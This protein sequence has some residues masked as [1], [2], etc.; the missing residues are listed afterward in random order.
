MTL[1]GGATTNGTVYELT[2]DSHGKWRHKTLHNFCVRSNCPDGAQPSSSL[3]ADTKGNL[4]GT[5]LAGGKTNNGVVFELMPPD[6]QRSKWKIKILH[7]F[8]LQTCTDGS[9]YGQDVIEGNLTYAGAASGA[10][11]D[12]V[13]ALYGTTHAGGQSIGNSGGVVYSLTPSG[14]KWQ[15]SV[16]YSFCTVS[17]CADG[18]AP[19]GGLVIDA[20]GN[21][22]GTTMI[23]GTGEGTA[24]ELSPNA[25][26]T[27][28]TETVLYNFCSSGCAG[29]AL[30]SGRLVI[31]TMGNL[32]GTSRLGGSG[33][34]G[35]AFKLVPNGTASQVTPLYDFCSQ[36][37]AESFCTDGTRPAA[38]LTL[39][40][41]GRLFGTT[42][43]GGG[44]SSDAPYGGGV[45]FMLNGT[46]QVIHPFCALF[47]C[48]DGEYPSSSLALDEAGNLYGTTDGGG[49]PVGIE[50]CYS[51][52][53]IRVDALA[54]SDHQIAGGISASC[55]GELESPGSTEGTGGPGRRDFEPRIR[56][57][58]RSCTN[59]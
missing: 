39:D 15:A 41:S 57:P 17:G 27:T 24:F 59:R 58:G 8:C 9:N 23:G 4:Y 56:L 47:D 22:Y 35:V 21:L 28:W 54:Q 18:Q 14:N 7:S 53:R 48:A 2:Q 36:N 55:A 34:G 16:L 12:G 38:G 31:D 45:A 29:G 40:A 43:Q 42:V 30:P 52:H 5:T 25:S 11:Y 26:K 49:T 20:A 44:G 37:D 50:E 33:A 1:Y 6:A 10:A 3:I 13:S 51:R 46:Q 32:F 19:E